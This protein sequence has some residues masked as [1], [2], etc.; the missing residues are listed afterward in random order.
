MN[1]EGQCSGTTTGETRWGF[2]HLVSLCAY[3]GHNPQLTADRYDFQMKHCIQCH[4]NGN[5]YL[6]WTKEEMKATHLK[7]WE[8]C[9]DTQLRRQNSWQQAGNSHEAVEPQT[10]AQIRNP[11]FVDNCGSSP[12]TCREYFSQICNVGRHHLRKVENQR[13][14]RK[15]WGE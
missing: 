1:N 2:E 14:L 3:L 6:Q 5:T 13:C 8:E 4:S 9:E 12:Q 15:V 11:G 7:Q 10:D